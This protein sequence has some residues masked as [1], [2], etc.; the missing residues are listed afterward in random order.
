MIFG[1]LKK[2]GRLSSR[3]EWDG[4]ATKVPFFMR[5]D[6]LERILGLKST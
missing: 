4:E 3:S 6:I 5:K 1:Y 2:P